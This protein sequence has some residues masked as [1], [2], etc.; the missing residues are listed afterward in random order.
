MRDRRVLDE[1]AECDSCRRPLS[2][3]FDMT[4]LTEPLDR[5]GLIVVVV[6]A[7]HEALHPAVR[8]D[9]RPDDDAGSNRPPQLAASA[10]LRIQI[11]AGPRIARHRP[12]LQGIP[13]CPALRH[14]AVPGAAFLLERIK[15]LYKPTSSAGFRLVDSHRQAAS[16]GESFGQ[17]QLDAINIGCPAY[18]TS[19]RE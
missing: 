1:R 8:A 13:A 15:R 17:G 9:G 19:K 16:R 14:V 3:K 11:V 6:V 12:T 18:S 7:L 4:G 10:K 5:V 2:V